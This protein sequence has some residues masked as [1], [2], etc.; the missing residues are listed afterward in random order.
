M[1][2]L[3]C[4][5]QVR[6]T[7]LVFQLNVLTE[8]N[9][10]GNIVTHVFPPEFQN[11]V[12]EG[13]RQ[14]GTQNDE[15]GRREDWMF[16]KKTNHQK[17]TDTNNLFAPHLL[18]LLRLVQTVKIS[19]GGRRHPAAINARKYEKREHQQNRGMKFHGKGENEKRHNKAILLK[20]HLTVNK[21]NDL[22]RTSRR[23]A[24]GGAG[25]GGE[26]KN[27]VKCVFVRRGTT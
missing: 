12:L 13:K 3:L 22:M 7:H 26:W 17:Q 9:I 6:R 15:R 18:L 8:V 1:T 10:P 27:E 16:P 2:V 20:S 24:R 25:G 4:N 21:S 14:A 23:W 5:I 11:K 19:R